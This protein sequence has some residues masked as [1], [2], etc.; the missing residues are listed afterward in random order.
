M[1]GEMKDED[2]AYEQL[3]Q[4]RIDNM[5]DPTET[6]FAGLARKIIDLEQQLANAVQ[7]LSDQD[8][9]YNRKTNELIERHA[10][11]LAEAQKQIVM[12]RELLEIVQERGD[13]YSS[14]HA[15]IRA[16]LD[17]TQDLPDL[18]LCYSTS[19]GDVT[20][21][22]KDSEGRMWHGI[23]WY[24]QNVSVPQGTKLYIAMR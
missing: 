20:R 9:E 12:L 8:F 17:A 6:Y 5:T 15:A 2:F 22:G 10:Q 1:E 3:R 4:K 21:Y 11:Q 23:N 13:L 7:M 16:A 14:D 18:V 19:V 24:D